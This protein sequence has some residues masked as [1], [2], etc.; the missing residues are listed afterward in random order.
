LWIAVLAACATPNPSRPRIACAAGENP[1]AGARLYV[2]DHSAIATA[3]QELR[4]SR[5]DDSRLLDK[6][7]GQPAGVWVGEWSG[8]VEA[9]VHSLGEKANAKGMVP[10]I[11]AYN[12]PNRDCGQYSAGGSASPDAYHR[13]IRGFAKGAEPFRMI[14]VLEPDALAQLTQCLSPVDQQA[15]LA[16]LKD[17]VDLLHTMP[18]VSAYLDAGHAKWI[19]APE[20]AQRLVAAGVEN[21]NGF[22]LNV[23]NYIGTEESVAYGRAVAAAIRGKHFIVD[24]SRNGN[25]ATADAQWCNPGGRALGNAPTTHTGDPLVDAFV[26][27]KRPGESD[28]TCNGG[29]KA[30]EFWLEAALGL[31]RRARW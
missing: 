21:A 24:T 19:A 9:A 7:A 6:I 10:V 28:G 1:F 13:W 20:M 2:D 11:V 12:V 26:W 30:G 14:V 17:A 18:G 3:A 8:D 4:A 27:V 16:M 31:A 22:A 29:P 15:R 25:A 5:P 23:S